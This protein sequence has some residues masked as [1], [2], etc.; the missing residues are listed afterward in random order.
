MRKY[1]HGLLLTLGLALTAQVLA[2]V[3]VLSIVGPLVIAILLGMAWRAARG[4]TAGA[5]PGIDFSGRILLR[6]GIV[7]LG[8]RLHLGDVVQAGAGSVAIALADIVFGLLVVY[9]LCRWLGVEAR[10]G[11]LTACGTAICGAA[12]VGAVGSQI[13]A[14]EEEVAVS[15]GIVALLGTGFTVVY[16]LVYPFLGLSSE[17]Y[18]LFSGATLHEIAHVL[19]AAAPAGSAAL[20]V[21][22]VAK[23]TR[24][25][26]LV[27]VALLIGWWAARQERGEQQGEGWKKVTLPWFLFGFLAAS[28]VHSLGIVPADWADRLVRLAYLLMTMAMAGL[29]LN[30]DPGAFRRHGTRALT[31]GLAGSALLSLFGYGL[32]RLLAYI[33]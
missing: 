2:R 7:L 15:T 6:T 17:L 14:R 28:G 32:V 19:A 9:G 27:P 31:A 11:M 3:P 25:A 16:T 26:L 13:N 30:A 21:A 4:V 1:V 29:G 18:G 23:L 8:M 33:H 24:V 5:V 12:A 10:I 22:V 20:D